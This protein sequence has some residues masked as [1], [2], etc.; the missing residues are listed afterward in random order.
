MIAEVDTLKEATNTRIAPH[1]ALAL[2]G[3]RGHEEATSE[4][5]AS[6]IAHATVSGQGTAVQYARWASSVLMNGLG[7]Y[8]EALAAA[9]EASEHSPELHITSWALTELIEAA[10]RTGDAQV[11]D[12]L[13][14]DL[15]STSRAARPIGRSGSMPGR[16]PC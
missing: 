1:A 2:A 16:P 11:A 14:V 13:L 7:R 3:I 4:L 15:V 9:V 6:V 8:E 12:M 10:T 5:V